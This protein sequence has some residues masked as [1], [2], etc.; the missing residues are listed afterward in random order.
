VTYGSGS[1][2]IHTDNAQSIAAVELYPNGVKIT[3]NTE[4]NPGAYTQ[5]AFYGNFNLE[6]SA[7]L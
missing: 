6:L 2:Q 5:G 4:L 7:D 1:A 3:V